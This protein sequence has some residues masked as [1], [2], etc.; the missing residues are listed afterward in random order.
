LQVVVGGLGV[1]CDVSD[2]SLVDKRLVPEVKAAIASQGRRVRLVSKIDGEDDVFLAVD[3]EGGDVG[4][5]A[6]GADS[7][8]RQAIPEK[9]RLVPIKIVWVAAVGRVPDPHD[10]ERPVLVEV[11]QVDADVGSTALDV[12]LGDD[13]PDGDTIPCLG[14]VRVG[15]GSDDVRRG[16]RRTAGG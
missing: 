13:E 11:R 1:A 14:A 8:A 5:E 6:V 10:V 2:G 4:L 7:A 9:L 16:G 12:P 15:E 3:V